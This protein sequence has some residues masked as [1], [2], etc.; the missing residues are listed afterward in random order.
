MPVSAKN[1]MRAMRA[2]KRTKAEKMDA[3][4]EGFEVEVTSTQTG[5]G[6]VVFS[7]PEETWGRMVAMAEAQGSTIE[8][9]ME[10]SI[11]RRTGQT[12]RKLN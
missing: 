5:D 11:K 1:R 4:F 10:T 2:R 6:V 9:F 7:A 8:E 3:I 12:P